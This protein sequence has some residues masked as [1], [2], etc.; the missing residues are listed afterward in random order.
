MFRRKCIH[1][2]FIKCKCVTNLRRATGKQTVHQNRRCRNTS[3]LAIVYDGQNPNAVKIKQER[4]SKETTATVNIYS[5]PSHVLPAHTHHRQHHHQ[6]FHFVNSFC[7]CCSSPFDSIII[8]ILPVLNSRIF[9][10]SRLFETMM[11]EKKKT[12]PP[13]TT[14]PFAWFFTLFHPIFYSFYFASAHFFFFRLRSPE[15]F[16]S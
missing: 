10:A 16:L 8:I 14:L 5:H 9:D 3:V 13:F 12:R 6:P 1:E 11:E 4:E 15:R 2:I 7:L